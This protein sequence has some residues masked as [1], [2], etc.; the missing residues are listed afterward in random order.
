MPK[1]TA[2]PEKYTHQLVVQLQDARDGI[3]SWEIFAEK[4]SCAEKLDLSV[5]NYVSV[6]PR[7]KACERF[8]TMQDRAISALYHTATKLPGF[9]VVAPGSEI[10]D[11][12][13]P[14]I[15]KIPDESRNKPNS[16]D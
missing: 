11:I 13:T 12:L 5:C 14:A 3:A 4:Y 8:A 7:L 15:K 2:A 1:Q 6:M 16:H 10:T 9:G